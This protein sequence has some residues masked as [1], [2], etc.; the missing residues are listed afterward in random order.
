LAG[1]S[2]VRL[3]S[4]VF[5]H[6]CIYLAPTVCTDSGNADPWALIR[7]SNMHEQ[8]L[9]AHSS[10]SATAPFLPACPHLQ[11]PAA[12][13]PREP[14][15]RVTGA[16]SPLGTSRSS[17][18]QDHHPRHRCPVWSMRERRSVGPQGSPT[19][20]AGLGARCV[21]SPSLTEDALPPPSLQAT[22][23]LCDVTAPRPGAPQ[24]QG[25][26]RCA[27]PRSL[28]GDTLPALPALSP[29]LTPSWACPLPAPPAPALPFTLCH[30]PSSA[31]GSRCGSFAQGDPLRGCRVGTLW[32][33][34]G[35]ATVTPAEQPWSRQ[36][37]RGAA[38]F[39]GT[40]M[41]VLCLPIVL[42]TPLPYRR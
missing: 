11:A 1:I 34:N 40:A 3:M 37:C 5:S 25:S 12:R 18:P 22:L 17:L 28:W 10:F 24:L 4:T 8:L 32:E 16:V 20:P 30:P 15:S 14:L 35:S 26:F 21:P 2:D 38:L 31:C 29:R 33:R 6:I 7:H 13:L 23:H 41:S 27:R 9:L 19:S 39:K 36:P 42:R